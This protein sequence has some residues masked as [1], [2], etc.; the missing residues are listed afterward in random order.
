MHCHSPI[1]G[2]LTRIIFRK[3]KTKVLY[4]AHG[5]HFYKDGP[6]INWLIFTQLKNF[7]PDTQIYYSQ[8]IMMIR[9]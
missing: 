1:G 3:L 9:I 8:S 6:K 2:V 4:T 7:Y 5:F